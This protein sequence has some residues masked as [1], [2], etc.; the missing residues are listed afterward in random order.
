[1][2]AFYV[3]LSATE[4]LQKIQGRLAPASPTLPEDMHCTLAYLGDPSDQEET[5]PELLVAIRRFASKF[6]PIAGE[7]VGTAQ[8]GRGDDGIPYVVLVDAPELPSFREALVAYLIEQVGMEV[9][10]N[11]GFMAHVTLSYEN[12]P[13]AHVE[14]AAIPVVFDRLTV[15]MGDVREHYRLGER[16]PVDVALDR[17]V[18]ATKSLFG[19]DRECLEEL[20]TLRVLPDVAA[21]EI[22]AGKQL[23]ISLAAVTLLQTV[24]G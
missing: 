5:L 11:H 15:A 10:M 4:A 8:F 23:G 14:F 19:D 20:E 12:E 16:H 21:L 24:E 7:L 22:E 13:K 2:V 6:D 1:M 17:V 18:D 3:P 9:A